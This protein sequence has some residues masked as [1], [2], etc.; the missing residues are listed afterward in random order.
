MGRRSIRQLGGRR[1]SVAWMNLLHER[2]RLLVAIAGVAFAV[3]LI[4]MNLGFLGALSAT[5]TNFYRQFNADLFLT[6]PETLEISST[7][8][9]PARS[10]VSGRGH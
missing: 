1:V 3:L 8:V 10:P 7:T 2:T 4:F 5:T 6:S 9:F